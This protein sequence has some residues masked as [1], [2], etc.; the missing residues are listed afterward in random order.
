[1]RRRSSWGQHLK[2]RDKGKKRKRENL[3]YWNGHHLKWYGHVMRME[4]DHVVRRVMTKAIP[5]KGREGD[6]P[7][8][9]NVLVY[10]ASSPQWT[11][12]ASACMTWTTSARFTDASGPNV[13]A[14]TAA[15]Y[16]NLTRRDGHHSRHKRTRQ[17]PSTKSTMN[18]QIREL[19]ITT[20]ITHAR[21]TV[22]VLQTE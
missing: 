4:E 21:N 20:T 2:H 10:L 19:S 15:R 3:L 12:S 13:I 8:G 14:I 22:T 11:M 9:R 17:H 1:M 7:H 18:D 16:T 5:G 6:S